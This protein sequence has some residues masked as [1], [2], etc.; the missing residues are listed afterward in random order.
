MM[1]RPK[2]KKKIEEPEQI[3]IYRFKFHYALGPYMSLV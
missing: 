1:E 3:H 2:K